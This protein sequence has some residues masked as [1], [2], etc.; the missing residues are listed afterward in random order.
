MAI[1]PVDIARKLGISTT[2]LRKYEEFGLTPPVPRSATGYRTYTHEHTAYLVCAREMLPAFTTKEIAV[3]YK[4]VMAKE[5]DTAL[6]IANKAQVDLYGEKI[7]AEKIVKNLLRKNKSQHTIGGK[8]LTINDIS[9]ETGV[10]TTTIRYWDK[11]GLI[12]A[13]RS[14]ENNYRI[15]TAEH[16]EQILA[17]CAL[18]FSTQVNRQKHS[19]EQIREGLRAFDYNDLNRI[20]TMTNGIEQYLNQVNRAQI[21]GISALYHLCVQVEAGH[22]DELL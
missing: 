1:R 3:I 16:V 5:I 11:V 15:F 18:R 21:K 13:G 9:R 22:F 8:K 12:S 4:S 17:I 10:P 14:T 20:R 6:W 19:I 2:T 7:I